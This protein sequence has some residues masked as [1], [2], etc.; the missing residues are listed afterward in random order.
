MSRRTKEQ[1]YVKR[2][3]RGDTGQYKEYDRVYRKAVRAAKTAYYAE[4]FKAN[5]SNLRKTW[6]LVREC[7]GKS[8]V[9]DTIPSMF[10]C[11]GE[12]GI[13]DLNIANGFNEFV[14]PG[15]VLSLP[16][17]LMMSIPR[18]L[19]ITSPPP[20]CINLHFLQSDGGHGAQIPW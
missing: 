11:I 1:L 17:N 12:Q 14:L 18:R 3:Q 8:Q 4:Q 10:N 9:R 13:G 16:G 5:A 6:G 7:Q 19:S 20:L 15:W 2:R